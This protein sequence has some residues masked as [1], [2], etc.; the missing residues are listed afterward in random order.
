MLKFFR[1]ISQ[2]ANLS[3]A[4]E[5]Q[6]D[7]AVYLYA[8]ATARE[9][10][11]AIDPET[12]DL[13]TSGNE[14]VVP[15]AGDILSFSQEEDLS[16]PARGLNTRQ[17]MRQ[18][19]SETGAPIFLTRG[20]AGKASKVKAPNG[21]AVSQDWVYATTATRMQESNAATSILPGQALIRHLLAQSERA[22][23]PPFVTG[24]L[25]TGTEIQVLILFV[26]DQE[27]A[28][29]SMQY[30]PLA[31]RGVQDAI[32]TYV[33]TVRLESAGLWD[34]ERIAIFTGKEILAAAKSA[35][36]YPRETSYAGIPV[37]V[38]WRASASISACALLITAV[39]SVWMQFHSA[40]Y[41][42]RL[43]SL[44]AR[45]KESEASLAL[46]LR[47]VRLGAFLDTSSVNV[48]QAI[49]EARALWTEGA[50]VSVTAEPTRRSIKVSNK[51]SASDDSPETLANAM[52]TKPPA[53]CVR[54][55][56][57]TTTQFNEVIV[58]YECTSGSSVLHR[59]N[60]DA[61]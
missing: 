52:Q 11:W 40:E 60:R 31:G 49:E 15:Q 42:S 50:K 61:R 2:R 1:S 55:P 22:F 21:N 47:E 48:R 41:N 45:Q 30:I 35:S 46:E 27:G 18:I 10:W 38:A 34:A 33:Q 7:K 37:S 16:T 26:C 51:L 24:C 3:E 36:P 29:N 57:Q 6:T 23:K 25:F 28:L 5:P 39:G 58:T 43:D 8:R 13:Q 20:H 14:A 17:L 44:K 54:D 4:K 53:G 12:G 9:A 32:K 56:V 19:M 59:L